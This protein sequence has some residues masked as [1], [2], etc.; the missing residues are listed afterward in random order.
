V[1]P[2]EAPE[3]QLF[4]VVE[5]ASAGIRMRVVPV[6]QHGERLAAVNHG[7]GVIPIEFL[8][9]GDHQ[10]LADAY[11]IF[12]RLDLSGTPAGNQDRLSEAFTAWREALAPSGI[13]LH[14]ERRALYGLPV[15][16][17]EWA[18]EP[19]GISVRPWDVELTAI[20][21]CLRK[22]VKFD[23]VPP[24]L[25][26]MLRQ[27]AEQRGLLVEIVEPHRAGGDTTDSTGAVTLLV[28]RDHSALVEAQGLE[29]VLC[30][31]GGAPG[32]MAATAA[33][34]E[35]LGYPRCCV[36][37]FARIAGQN[38]TTLAWALLPALPGT[39]ASPLTQW[40]QPPLWLL[41]HFPC[42]L[43]CAASIAL[44]QRLLDALEAKEH[45]F[46]ARWC[47]LAAR[48]QVVD[49][50]GNRMALAVEGSLEAGARIDAADV[51]GAGGPDPDAAPRARSLVGREVRLD[52]GGLV[53]AACGWYAPYVAD[54]RGEP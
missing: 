50:R 28:A 15:P 33:M 23:Q 2:C 3:R 49:Q 5:R 38:D 14:L 29:Q 20:E 54:H 27:H 9:E 6:R 53:I 47:S 52:A 31:R 16:R 7:V 22:I 26:G 45:G 44:G 32:A 51:L 21:A 34:G 39:P 41:S 35:L 17:S 43:H 11:H 36:Q 25:V 18:T 40:L 37:R 1:T 10:S 48:V 13:R 46:S 42:D 12:R 19:R 30:V 4:V 24:G 8:G